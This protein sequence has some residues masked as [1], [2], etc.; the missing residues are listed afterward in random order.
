MAQIEDDKQIAGIIKNKAK[1]FVRG[2][3]NVSRAFFRQAIGIYLISS[4]EVSGL[5]R[6][7]VTQ[8]NKALQLARSNDELM[9]VAQI[10]VKRAEMR[11]R[12]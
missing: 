3:A 10:I 12:P 1:Q 9:P 5:L 4:E 11:C 7:Q 2:K 6:I 8:V